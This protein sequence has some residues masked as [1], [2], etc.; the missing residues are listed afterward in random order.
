MRGVV[1]RAGRDTP[2]TGGVRR[3]PGHRTLAGAPCNRTTALHTGLV[4]AIRS[5]SSGPI[6]APL[7]ERGGYC[8]C[9][10]LFNVARSVPGARATQAA[11]ARRSTAAFSEA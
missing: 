11:H 9:G 6:I 10:A 7:G 1:E 4:W 8:D 2:K 3:A 5:G